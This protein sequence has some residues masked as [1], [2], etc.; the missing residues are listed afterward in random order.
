MQAKSINKALLQFAISACCIVG[1]WLL[2]SQVDW[3][4]VLGIQKITDK[5]EERLG[6]LLWQYYSKAEEESKSEYVAATVD[7]IV[8]HLCA[9][10][11]IDR[12]FIKVHIIKSEEPNAFALPN[13]HLVVLTGLFTDTKN[14]EEMTGV[15][16]HEI[17]HIQLKHV[18]KKLSKE[19]GISVLLSIT[20]NGSGGE[21]LGQTAK[22]LTSSAFDRAMEKE[23]DLKAVEYLQN[24]Q[25]NPVPFS[26]LLGR[27]AE[28]ESE[29]EEYISWTSSHPA[30]QERSQYVLEMANAKSITY[31]TIISDSTWE[32]CKE[33]VVR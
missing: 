3:I 12:Q 26:D 4:S 30:S 18:M 10:N 5:T 15:L 14:Y 1:V 29:I 32:K 9:S 22:V 23:A 2:L 21:V 25:I 6:D 24:A 27:F 11:N 19:I 13:G 20:T 7:S 8:D 33:I 16:G 31:Q 17:A 28:K